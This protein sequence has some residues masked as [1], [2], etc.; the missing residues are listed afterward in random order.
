MIKNREL[1]SLLVEKTLELDKSNM[2]IQE[3]DCILG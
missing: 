2:R 1:E 3:K